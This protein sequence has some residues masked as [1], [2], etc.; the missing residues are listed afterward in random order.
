L[1]LPSLLKPDREFREEP[2]ER[3]QEL[4][5]SPTIL[6]KRKDEPFGGEAETERAYIVLCRPAKL[7]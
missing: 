1:N 7:K 3:Y 5:K 6:G 2:A 4:E